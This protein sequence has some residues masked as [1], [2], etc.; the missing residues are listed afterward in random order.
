M[1]AR[2]GILKALHRD[3]VREFNPDRKD[4]IGASGSRSGTS[5]LRHEASNETARRMFLPGDNAPSRAPWRLR[6]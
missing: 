3:V 4:T 1:L 5:R 2:I 6:P